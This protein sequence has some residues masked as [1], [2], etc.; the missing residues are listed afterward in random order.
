MF[1]SNPKKEKNG[2]NFYH[3]IIVGIATYSPKA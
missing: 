3:G 1:R 2:F